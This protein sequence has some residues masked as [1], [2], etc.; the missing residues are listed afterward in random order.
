LVEAL[1]ERGISQ[2]ELARRTDR[3]PKTINEIAKGKAAIT[4]DTAIQLELVLGIPARF[5]NNLQRDF[6]EAEARAEADRRLATDVDWVQLFPI[7]PMKALGWIR[8]SGSKSEQLAE[9]L[10]FFAV[11]SPAAW[12]RHWSSAQAAFRRSPAFTPSPY[13]VSAWLRRGEL[14]AAAISAPT[15]DA[16]ALRSRL[17]E[18]RRLVTLD[19]L[20]F[21]ADL[22]DLLTACGV[23]LVLTKELP[24]THLSG[25]TRWVGGR[26]VIQLSLRHKSDDQFWSAIF[27]EFG[28]VLQGGPRSAYLDGIEPEAIK[29]ADEIAADRFAANQLI[30]LADVEALRDAA[31]LLPA[32]IEGLAVNLGVS[33][34]ILLGRLQREGIVDPADYNFLK[35]FW[36]WG[37]ER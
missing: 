17:P 30:P 14:Q 2:A 31:H 16:Q 19:P 13:A 11:S 6:S 1:E 22:R 28:H 35:R 5:W 24:G 3:P 9:L 23:I 34:G 29:G 12:E 15:F 27:H 8:G 18:L 26:P 25:A 37:D 33:P 10:R 20:A 21:M 7:G 36:K 32:Q 4:P